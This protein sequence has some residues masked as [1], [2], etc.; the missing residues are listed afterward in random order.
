MCQHIGP[1]A[2]GSWDFIWGTVHPLISPIPCL[3]IAFSCIIGWP[4]IFLF[5]NSF[6]LCKT[7]MVTLSPHNHTLN[8]K[9]LMASHNALSLNAVKSVGHQNTEV[10]GKVGKRRNQLLCLKNQPRYQKSSLQ[11]SYNSTETFDVKTNYKNS[12]EFYW[13]CALS[14][15]FCPVHMFCNLVP[16]GFSLWCI[17]QKRKMSL[18]KVWNLRFRSWTPLTQGL[19][20]LFQK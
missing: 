16:W 4:N 2:I 20:I 12:T 17:C 14:Q 19:R 5:Q 13:T 10:I 9:T 7:Y 11:L 3:Q 15:F 18:R 8:G 1:L 6:C